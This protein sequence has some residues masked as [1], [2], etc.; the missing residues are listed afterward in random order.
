MWDGLAILLL[1]SIVMGTA[2]F[3]AG[4]LPLSFSLSQRQLRLITALGTGVLV[5]T[6]LIVIIPEGVETLYSAS[7][8]S[9]GHSERSLSL[10]TRGATVQPYLHAAAIEH[11]VRQETEPLAFPDQAID[12]T[13]RTGPDDGFQTPKD[14][15]HAEP[16]S[17]DPGHEP[18]VVT[19][20]P[21]DPSTEAEDSGHD[22]H[23]WIG[24]SL[25]LGFI[26]M[27]LI[28]TL[29]RQASSSTAPQRFQVSLNNFSL[30]RTPSASNDVPSDPEAESFATNTPQHSSSRP[31]ST[32][33][34]LVIHAAADGIALG[35][36]S[37]GPSNHLSFVIF[38]ALIIHKAPA[39]FGLT[40]VLL[41]Q[42]L[43]KRMAR[44]RLI[45]FSLAA[46]VGALM[47]WSA[48]HI[49]GFSSSSLGESASTEFA[50][51]VL[52]LFSGGTFLY[53]AMHTMQ[54][55]AT[56]GHLHEAHMMNGYAG[57]PLDDAYAVQSPPSLKPATTA[58]VDTLV[59]VGGMLLPLLTQFGHGH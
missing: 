32:T 43:S 37:T 26:L 16:P 10:T 1:L 11:Q 25:I 6:S 50:T 51:G 53:V 54:G 15:S 19:Q 48:V 44:A 39:A 49:L 22:P 9:H 29:P 52:L 47:T 42:G 30:N 33:V 40:T 12:N 18:G 41:K 56:D 17:S 59:T 28:D 4:S 20:H 34:G 55:N 8:S 38:I 2:S 3:L 45:V 36:S 31:S 27:Y 7:G 57:V 35:A 21:S 46:P 5:G 58:M 23:A 14:A 24:I 13:F